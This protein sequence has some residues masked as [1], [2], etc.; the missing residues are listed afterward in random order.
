MKERG[1]EKGGRSRK[2][3]EGSG[4]GGN[5]LQRLMGKGGTG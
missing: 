1:W 2:E 5:G 3:G 4:R